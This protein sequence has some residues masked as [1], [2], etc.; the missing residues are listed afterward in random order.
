MSDIAEKAAEVTA[1]VVE[2]TVDG[3]VDVVEVVRSNPIALVAVGLAGVAAGLVGGYFIAQKRLKAHYELIAS[4]EIA[5]AKSFY[6]SLNKVDEDGAVLT[7]QEVME[8]RHGSEEAAAALRVYR[9]NESA[10]NA[11]SS[12]KVE[13]FEDEDDEQD[14]EQLRKIEKRK[15]KKEKAVNVFEAPRFD[16]EEEMKYRTEDKPYIITHDEYFAGEKDYEQVSVTYFEADD[17]LV[18]FH[19]KPI[20]QVDKVIGEDHLVMFGSGSGD[21]NIV[22]IRNDRL[23][24]DYEVVRSKGSYVEE[25]LGML[26]SDETSLKHADQLSRRRAFRHG[27]G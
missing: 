11:S 6:A 24:L 25:V 3:I 26:D 23:E 12:D 10:T 5:E 21:K 18:D 19:D 8:R 17:T 20:E 4:E 15:A 13:F 22:Y 2:E 14:E 9:G 7:P 16:L 1:E 27:D